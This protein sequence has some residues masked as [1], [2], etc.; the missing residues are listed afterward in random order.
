MYYDVLEDVSK[1]VAA[2]AVNKANARFV[3]REDFLNEICCEIVED[4]EN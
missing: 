1:Y 4:L 2:D 3:V